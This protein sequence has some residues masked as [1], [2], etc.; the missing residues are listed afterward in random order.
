MNLIARL[1]YELAYYDSAVHR[2]NHYTT[3][4]PPLQT[5]NWLQLFLSNTDYSISMLFIHL[6]TANCSSDYSISIIQFRYTVKEFQ[7]LLVKTYYS[8]HHCSFVKLF[9]ILLCITNNSIK[10]HTFL[11]SQLNDQTVLFLTIQFSKSHFFA[12]SLNLKQLYL[13]H[14]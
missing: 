5:E 7:V 1:G 9:E 6:H 14:R 13:T 2:F 3:R 4:T 11:N 10:Y 8:I 12:H